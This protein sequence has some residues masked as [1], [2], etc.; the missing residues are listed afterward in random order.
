MGGLYKVVKVFSSSSYI[1]GNV[2]SFSPFTPN[3]PLDEIL[4]DPNEHY[5]DPEAAED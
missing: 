2:G 5:A 1:V 3:T 4:D